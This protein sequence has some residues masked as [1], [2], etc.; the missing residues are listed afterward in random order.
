MQNKQESTDVYNQAAWTLTWI[1]SMK[2]ISKAQIIELYF[3][4]WKFEA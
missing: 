4:I 1:L 3:V 2:R